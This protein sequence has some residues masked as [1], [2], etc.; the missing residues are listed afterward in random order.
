M[1]PYLQN[2]S[3]DTNFCISDVR[4]V[5]QNG[6]RLWPLGRVGKVPE[7]GWFWRERSDEVI[8]DRCERADG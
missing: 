7:C 4:L 6:E 3:R 2:I 8:L 1:I 5:L